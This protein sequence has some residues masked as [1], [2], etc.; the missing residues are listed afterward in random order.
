ML[1][2]SSSADADFEAEMAYVQDKVNAGADFIITQM[3]FDSAVY[4]SYV[5]A[6]RDRCRNILTRVVRRVFF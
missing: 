3:F 2:S 5:N 1:F 6:C 4:A